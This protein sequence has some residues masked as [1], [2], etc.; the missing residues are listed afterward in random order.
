MKLSSEE[1]DHF[2]TLESLE[3]EVFS[4]QERDALRVKAEGRA[5]LRRA[6][7]EDVSREIAAYMA[8]EGIGF[9]ELTR[10]L[11]VSPA[12]TSKLMRG[13]GNITLE[14]IAQ[15]SELLGKKPSLAFS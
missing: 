13:S 9:N 6:L 11:A 2:Q 7:A 4:E 10:R 3:E 15:I 14:T 1:L 12:T 8:R 5:R